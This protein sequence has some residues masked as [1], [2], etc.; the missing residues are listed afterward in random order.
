MVQGVL[1]VGRVRYEST[2]TNYVIFF[3]ADSE[4]KYNS[5][6]DIRYSL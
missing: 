3:F 2:D 5:A 1:Q 4:Y 6:P